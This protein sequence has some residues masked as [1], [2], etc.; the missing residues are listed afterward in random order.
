M[1]RQYTVECEKC[2]ATW[3]TPV[4]TLDRLLLALGCT[5]YCDHGPH[6]TFPS[7]LRHT[8]VTPYEGKLLPP[9]R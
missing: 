9:S 7:L 8:T 2:G 3:V 4:L 6:P 5:T 1:K